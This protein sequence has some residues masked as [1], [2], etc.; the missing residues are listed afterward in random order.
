MSNPE[1]KVKKVK[2]EKVIDYSK[3]PDDIWEKELKAFSE[4]CEDIAQRLGWVERCII[5][6]EKQRVIDSQKADTQ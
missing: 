3:M 4:M 2:V 6:I 5:R 1:K